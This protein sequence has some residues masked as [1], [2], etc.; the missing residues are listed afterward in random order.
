MYRLGLQHAS[1]FSKRNFPAGLV[2]GMSRA[3]QQL[4]T[5]MLT[6]IFAT[7]LSKPKRQGGAGRVFQTRPTRRVE[8]CQV[9]RRWKCLSYAEKCTPSRAAKTFA[10]ASVGGI[11]QQFRTLERRLSSQCGAGKGHP[12]KAAR[13]LG[14]VYPGS[15]VPVED[16]DAVLIFAT[17]RLKSNAMARTTANSKNV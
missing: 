10:A 6:W 3:V 1:S 8:L 2:T 15:G 7:Y 13:K 5:S 4:R 17:R 9:W 12:F 16:G 14:T 11:T